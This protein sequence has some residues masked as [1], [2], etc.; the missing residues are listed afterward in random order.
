MI[1]METSEE[2]MARRYLI[3][4]MEVSGK[5]TKDLLAASS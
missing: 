1:A 2:W 5:D 3:F 4:D